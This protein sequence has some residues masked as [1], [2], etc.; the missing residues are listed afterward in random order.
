M[1]ATFNLWMSRLAYDTFALVINLINEAWVPCY[2][3]I[4]LFEAFTTFGAIFVEQV[5]VMLVEFNSTNKV[6]VYVKDD[7]EFFHNCPHFYCVGGFCFGHVISKHVNML[8]MEL[9]L[10]WA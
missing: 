6:I 9:R 10:I 2:I 7:F 4:G 5:K 8:P 1:I 3:I